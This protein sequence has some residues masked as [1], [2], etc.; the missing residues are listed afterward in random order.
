MITIKM[1]V[2]SARFPNKMASMKR[3]LGL[4]I[5]LMVILNVPVAPSRAK[6]IMGVTIHI[7]ANG[8]VDPQNASISSLDNVTYTF[9]SNITSSIVVEKDNII[10]DGNGYSLKGLGDGYGFYL[11]RIDNV[12]IRRTRIE[13]FM[14]G[15]H[16]YMATDIKICENTITTNNGYGVH[17]NFSS[18][19]TTIGNDITSNKDH[20]IF[21]DCSPY[22]TVSGNILTKNKCGFFLDEAHDNKINGNIIAES[23]YYGIH[24]YL[25]NNNTVANNTIRTSSDDGVCMLKCADNYVVGNDIIERN[26]DGISLEN[27]HTNIIINN[28]IISSK[29]DGIELSRSL[30]NEICG[31]NITSNYDEGV[32]LLYSLNNSLLGNRITKN[33]AN[34]IGLTNSSHN[35]ISRNV[36]MNNDDGVHIYGSFANIIYHNNFINNTHQ[37]HLEYSPDNFWDDGIEGNY[38]SDYGNSDSN[39]DGIGDAP[40]MIDEANW[41]NYPLMGMSYNFNV[42]LNYSVNIISNSTIEKVEYFEPNNTLIIF[43][44]NITEVQEF[45]FCR[46]SIPMSLIRPPYKVIVNNGTGKILYSNNALYA[47]ETHI[48][49]YLAYEKSIRTITIFTDRGNYY[50]LLI[51]AALC[52]ALVVPIIVHRKKKQSKVTK[53]MDKNTWFQQ[54]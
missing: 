22:N 16:L 23:S 35:T 18:N 24:M 44:S 12:T 3:K 5:T 33:G 48:C 10:I 15:I 36:L 1:S 40:I 43:L 9:S 6:T 31:N 21:L 2:D 39:Q 19:T 45:G 20:G 46:I 53:S 37:V 42:F 52:V 50:L 29:D 8:T 17:I 38:W 26:Y 30:S 7:R 14:E 34:G 49:I 13:G 32:F 27:S 51:A 25:S 47:N 11:Y 41:D 28:N 4:F 54:T